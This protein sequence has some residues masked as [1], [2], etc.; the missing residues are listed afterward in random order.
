MPETHITMSFLIFHLP[1]YLALCLTLLLVLCLISLIDLT[2]AHDFGSRKNSF[3]PRRFGYG[4]RFHHGDHFLHR[5]S[6]PAIG[7]HTHFE[8]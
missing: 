2:I 1:L 5:P 4:P 3:L 7:S 8:L 6:F